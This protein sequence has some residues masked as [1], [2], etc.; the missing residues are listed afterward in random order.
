MPLPKWLYCDIDNTLTLADKRGAA[1]AFDRIARLKRLIDAGV[2]VVLWTMSGSGYARR[3]AQRHGI[4]AVACLHKPNM[5]VD[6]KAPLFRP[7][8]KL[9][10]VLPEE[11]PDV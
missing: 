7:A 3:F 10:V 4:K 1:P 11:M 2:N 9:K 5:I 6:D 8:D